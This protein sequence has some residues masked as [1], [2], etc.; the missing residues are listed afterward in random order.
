MDT[1]INVGNNMTA[2]NRS[3]IPQWMR[4]CWCGKPAICFLIRDYTSGSPYLCEDHCPKAVLSMPPNSELIET[5]NGKQVGRIIRFPTHTPAYPEHSILHHPKTD[6]YID[7]YNIYTH[8]YCLFESSIEYDYMWLLISKYTT[9]SK[10][11]DEVIIDDK[12]FSINICPNCGQGSR[13]SDISWER[14][15]HGEYLPS[16]WICP[17]CGER[18]F[19]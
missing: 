17:E 4:T 12:G 5:Y 7:R 8:T 15:P 11:Y 16:F 1:A 9:Y 13:N 10:E 19:L 6:D 3:F 18:W 2:D 14:E